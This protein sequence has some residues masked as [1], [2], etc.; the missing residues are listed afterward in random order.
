MFSDSEMGLKE[1]RAQNPKIFFMIFTFKIYFQMNE[2]Y[3]I[4]E[5]I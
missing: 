4:F 1:F 2:S 3:Q 5:N